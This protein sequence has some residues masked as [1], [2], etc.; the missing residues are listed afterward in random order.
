MHI[1][2]LW[3]PRREMLT[4]ALLAWLNGRS[5][6]LIKRLL[7][8]CAALIALLLLWPGL[9]LIAL[10]IRRDS[11]G[12]VLF[13]QTRVGARPR[14]HGLQLSW[15]E[16]LFTCYKFRTMLSGCDEQPHID[17]I[18]HFVSGQL[19]AG[20]SS[21]L[22]YKLCAD[23]RVTR[24]GRWLRKLSLDELPQLWNIFTGEMSFVGPRPVPVYEVAAYKPWHRQRLKALPGL[25]GMW[26][27]YGR[28]RVT[29]DEMARLDIDYIRRRSL[30]LDLKLLLA[31]LPAV[32]KKEGAA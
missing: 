8:V 28:S 17:Y 9:L 21:H 25:T 1:E 31:T 29:F 13:R 22:P 2:T 18:V 12:P 14:W 26:Q 4:P 3:P 20:E 11:P 19:E 27:V 6:A 24:V 5:Y 10:L 30:L 32:L 7:D 16:R 23:E 15:E